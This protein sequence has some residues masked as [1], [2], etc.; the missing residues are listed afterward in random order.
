[1]KNWVTEQNRTNIE[2]IKSNSKISKFSSAEYDVAG[3]IIPLY[4]RM[5]KQLV[6]KIISFWDSAVYLK[7]VVCAF[8]K[9]W[10]GGDV[11]LRVKT[12][13]IKLMIQR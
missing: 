12:V 1:M 6:E 2:A 5:T 3:K 4:T 10:R 11:T 13:V 8:R 9:T 7:W